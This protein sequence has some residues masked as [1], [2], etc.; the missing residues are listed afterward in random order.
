M[1]G[2]ARQVSLGVIA[3][4]TVTTLIPRGAE[5]GNTNWGLR[6]TTSARPRE[7]RKREFRRAWTEF[8]ACVTPST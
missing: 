4:I 1:I 6:I 3:V 5:G 8:V 2:G 7:W